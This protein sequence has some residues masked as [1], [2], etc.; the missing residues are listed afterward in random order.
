MSLIRQVASNT[1]LLSGAQI[2]S[3]MTSV[4]LVS[5]IARSQG[6]EGLGR[7]ALVLA[8][9]YMASS[10]GALGLDKAISR[11]LARQRHRAS[12][13]FSV[14]TVA[15]VFMGLL[16][17]GG[18]LGFSALSHGPDVQH[19]LGIMAFAIVPS[20]LITHYESIFMAFHKAKYVALIAVS[21]NVAKVAIGV[22]A[23][24]AGAGIE[25][26][27]VTIAGLRF[28]TLVVYWIAFRTSIAP[29]TFGFDAMIAR[30]LR[31]VSPIF[32][33]EQVLGT[34]VNRLDILMLA[35]YADMATVGYYSAALRLVEIARLVPS[36]FMRAALPAM[37]ETLAQQTQDC[38]QLL[39][40]SVRYMSLYALAAVAGT[41]LLASLMLRI[42][43][44]P[45]FESAEPLLRLL[46]LVLIPGTMGSVFASLM[47]AGNLEALNLAAQV[48]GM[49][50]RV[51]LCVLLIPV[52]SATG[53]AISVV[54]SQVLFIATLMLLLVR[55]GTTRNRAI[56]EVLRMA[57]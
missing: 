32:V 3:P 43:Y 53:A 17:T 9:F 50:L 10:L 20:V 49:L 13:F 22:A 2:V 11:S 41:W 27:F 37:S 8:I 33:S 28:A 14:L 29:V 7:Y 36:S 39:R 42:L 1:A 45:G 19:A 38:R 40:T 46:A 54:A 24:L 25:A 15:G 35:Q 23:L 55:V 6:A 5:A 48:S 47:L 57:P 34:V 30:E 44:G 52:W 16:A 21:E 26:I 4:L 31:D 56:G 51:V 12:D 18:A